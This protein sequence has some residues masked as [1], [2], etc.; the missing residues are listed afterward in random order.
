MEI[1]NNYALAALLVI[2]IGLGYLCYKL[3]RWAFTDND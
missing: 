3:G 1:V 2:I